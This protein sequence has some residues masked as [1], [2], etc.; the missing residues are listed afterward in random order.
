M[1]VDT[2]V[3]CGATYFGVKGHQSYTDH[4]LITTYLVES[5]EAFVE[6]ADE[7]GKAYDQA[8]RAVG[9]WHKHG[10]PHTC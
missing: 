3:K 5:T 2:F 10:A 6:A 8:V 1:F 4:I 7:E 9:A